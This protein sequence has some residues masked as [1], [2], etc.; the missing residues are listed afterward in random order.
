M[1]FIRAEIPRFARNDKMGCFLRSLQKPARDLR[2]DGDRSSCGKF[3]RKEVRVM[4]IKKVGVV[5]CGLMGSGI[6]QVSATAGF[7]VT[8]LEVDQKY[9][10]K[11]FQAIRKSLDKLA[12]KGAFADT[13]DAIVSRL[14]GT[15]RKEDLADC[16]FVVE[17]VI[18]NVGEKRKTFAALDSV[19]KPSAIFASN[20]SSISITEIMTSTQ[21]PSQFVGLH[22]FN[23]VPLMKLVEVARTIVTTDEAFET[24]FEFGKKLGKVPVRTSDKTGFIVNRLLVPYLLDAIRAFEEGVGS[25]ADIDASMKLGCGYPMG[26]FTLLD[27]VGHDT[28]YYITQVM[29]DEFKEKRF[30]TPSLLKRMVMAGWYGKKNGKGFYDWSNPEKPV[31]QDAALRGLAKQ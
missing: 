27:F 6:A 13:P 11:G 22:F 24:A 30:A 23:P 17:A 2:Y 5:G 10:D 26:P 7:D 14:K 1:A 28:T 16:D 29:F 25:I 18:E 4:E 3:A 31:P 12:A 8:V 15:T 21:R 20:T 19:V 9:I